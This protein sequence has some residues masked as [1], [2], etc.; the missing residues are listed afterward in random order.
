VASLWKHPKSPFWSACFT[1]RPSNL[2]PAQ[3]WKRSL[4]TEDRKLARQIADML[5]EAARNVL[6][7]KEITAFIEKIRDSKGKAAVAQIFADVF[8]S[9]S[10]REF[11]VGS[12]RGFAD[13]WLT[14][15]KSQ[16]SSRS[17][18]KYKAAVQAFLT[19]L[20]KV[21]DR[22]LIG[23]GPRD[24]V[25][26]IQ[27]RDHL[28]ERLAPGSVNDK[29]KII[30]QMFKTASRRFKIESPAHFVPGVWENTAQ[31]GQRRAFTLSEIG[32][33]LR[34]AQG[35]EWEGI[36]LAGLYTGQR[37][38]DLAMLRWE[39]V[40]LARGEIALTTRK[41]NRRILIPIAAL[42]LD[43]LLKVP[44]SRTKTPL[45]GPFDGDRLRIISN[46]TSKWGWGTSKRFG[47]SR[48]GPPQCL[49]KFHQPRSARLSRR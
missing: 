26:V 7:E 45:R 33:I 23:F 47:R 11:G 42:L 19:F 37:L 17:Y 2:L 12:L 41:T 32:R 28:A 27:F 15:V 25:L 20:G 36:I 30:R 1:V 22:D 40:D 3:R 35:S 24:D 14:G 6:S 48:R 43:Y 38:S 39:N 29:L 9:V 8:R 21:A 10:G 31:A 5:D 46:R 13:S 4:R 44:A 18:P 34:T 49:A 16:L